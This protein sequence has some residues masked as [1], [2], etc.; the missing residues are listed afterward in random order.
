M[1]RNDKAEKISITLPSDMLAKV[2]SSVESGEYGSTSEVIRDAM[3]VWQS[4]R[5][6]YDA[7]LALIR[8][9]LENAQNSGAPIPLEDAFEQIEDLHTKRKN[10]QENEDL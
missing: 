2:K 6:E 10:K 5:D 3:R 7:R 9:R 8:Q 4:Q 1:A